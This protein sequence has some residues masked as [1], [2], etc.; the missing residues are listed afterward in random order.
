MSTNILRDVGLLLTN[1]RIVIFM[2]FCIFIGMCT[3]LVWNFLFWLIEYLA[4]NQE[5]CDFMTWIKTLQGLVGAVQCLLGE[6]PLFFLSGWILKRIG[7]VNAISLILL[8]IGIRFVLYSV[9]K[10]PWWFLPVE[11]TNGVTFGLFYATMA[12]YASAVAPSGTETTVQVRFFCFNLRI[13][14]I[15]QICCC[16][17]WLEQFSKVSVSL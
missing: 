1:F 6:L 9:I 3:G 7:H 17:D 2:L 16:R 15:I 5:G 12:S 4:E 13:F 11:L 8:V 10:N 14:G